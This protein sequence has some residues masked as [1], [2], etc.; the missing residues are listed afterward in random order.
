ML[1]MVLGIALGFVIGYLYGSERARDEAL[2]L[3]ESAPE[4]VRQATGRVSDAIAG[5]PVPDAVKQAATRATAAVQT[6]TERMAQAAAS[7]LE[8]AQSN[9]SG[10]VGGPSESPPQRESEAPSS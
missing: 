5:S 3:L 10:M 9:S 7:T 4:P 2:R 8:A 6:E 1:R